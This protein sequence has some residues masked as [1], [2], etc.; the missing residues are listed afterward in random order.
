MTTY[1]FYAFM[2]TYLGRKKLSISN[3][4]IPVMLDCF[5]MRLLIPFIAAIVVTLI[6]N[7]QLVFIPIVVFVMMNIGTLRSMY[8]MI[9]KLI[10]NPKIVDI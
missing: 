5:P 4:F 3:S 2:C 1:L 9:K 8:V 10:I 7:P 6:N